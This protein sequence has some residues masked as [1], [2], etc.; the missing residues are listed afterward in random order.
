MPDIRVAIAGLGAVGRVLAQRLGAGIPGL[1]LAAVA[2]RDTA[3]AQAWLDAQALRCPIVALTEFPTHA[4]L[5]VECA[6]PPLLE[7]IC[8]PMLEA[9][10]TAMVISAGALLPRPDLI[11]LAKRHG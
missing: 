6:P 5:A 11:E 10:K 3:K 2:A 8:R 4:D 9:G 1:Q 7:Q